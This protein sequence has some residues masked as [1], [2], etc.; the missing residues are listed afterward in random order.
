M[1]IV[2]NFTVNLAFITK[3]LALGVTTTPLPEVPS[4][5]LK[6]VNKF[7]TTTISSS[8]LNS[9]NFVVFYQ[10]NKIKTSSRVLYFLNNGARQKTV[11]LQ[12]FFIT[13]IIFTIENSDRTNL[14]IKAPPVIYSISEI[15]RLMPIMYLYIHIKSAYTLI[16]YAYLCKNN[17]F[18]SV[19]NTATL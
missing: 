3:N 8:K 11:R 2:E 1:Q 7:L 14:F 9:N 12:L 16:I 5:F 6:T 10:K 13:I 17:T 4:R 18:F 19:S 15:N